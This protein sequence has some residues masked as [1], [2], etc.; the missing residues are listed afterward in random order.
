MEG[1]EWQAGSSTLTQ[2]AIQGRR[3]TQPKA[4]TRIPI[5]PAALLLI[6]HKIKESEWPVIKKRL[7][8]SICTTMFVGSLCV[9][10]VLAV[11]S[12]KHVKGSTLLGKNVSLASV[13]INGQTKQYAKVRLDNP[14]EDR[15]KLGADVELF[16]LPELFFDPVDALNKWL[17]NSKL[18]KEDNLPLYR[19]ESGRNVTPAEFNSILK[20]LLKDSIKYEDGKVSSHSFRSGVASTMAKLGYTE[21][22]IQLQGRWVSQ[23]YLRY[24]KLGRSQKLDDQFK[25]FRGLHEAAKQANID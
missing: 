7:I 23:A 3:N 19:W 13:K 10:E 11:S 5:T 2:A 1:L 25:L 6:K 20:E 8:W 9:G 21:E 4:K 14:K 12:N 17:R 24:C 16:S 15:A 18:S 22:A